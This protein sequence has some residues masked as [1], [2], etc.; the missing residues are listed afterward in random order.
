MNERNRAVRKAVKGR[1]RASRELVNGKP[2]LDTPGPEGAAFVGWVLLQV[3]EP[4]G[5]RD[6][7]AINWSGDETKLFPTAIRELQSQPPF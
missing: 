4:R 7:V 2:W 1:Q 5:G 3:W 6:S